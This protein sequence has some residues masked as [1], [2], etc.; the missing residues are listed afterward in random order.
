M[1]RDWHESRAG[2]QPLYG[3][4]NEFVSIESALEFLDAHPIYEGSGVFQKYEI[5][6]EF[7][8][9]DKVDAFFSTKQKVRDFLNF[10][11]TQ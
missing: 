11:A 6:V 2:R 10:I 7:S 9:G 8:N 3:R 1:L 5:L 4:L